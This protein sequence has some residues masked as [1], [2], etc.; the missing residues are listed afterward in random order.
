[1]TSSPPALLTLRGVS[2]GFERRQVLANVDLTIPS[3][4]VVGVVG[5]GGVGKSTL[6]R[7]LARV[8]EALP[9][10]WLD[11]EITWRDGSS[12]LDMPVERAHAAVP[13]LAQKAGLYTA[14]V[15][16]NAIDGM[17]GDT[18]LSRADKRDLAR[19]ALAPLDL[20]SAFADVLDEPVLS[21]SIGRQR[22]LS[23]ARLLAGGAQ[24]ILADEPLRDITDEEADDIASLLRRWSRD[25]AV[26]VITHQQQR[27]RA[28]CDEICLLAGGR[29]V[30]VTP[31]PTFFDAPRT[32]LGADYVRSGNCWPDTPA[33]D[34]HAVDA[35]ELPPAFLR[36]FHWVID[37]RLGGTQ[38]PGLLGTEV[39]DL[40]AL[41][42]YGCD[43][44]ITL[45]EEPFPPDLVEDHG[46]EPVHFPI[47]DM[48][49]PSAVDTRHLCEQVSSWVDAG[50]ATVMHCRAGLGRTGTMLA[51]V[52]VYRG[53]SAVSAVHEVRSINPYYIQSEAQLRFLTEFHDY[54]R[55]GGTAAS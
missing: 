31:A 50:K 17:R 22:L 13:L 15:L 47:V 49:V 21:L 14:S 16:D 2:L 39:D 29:V 10:F 38:W 5:P 20:W 28:M 7:T 52:L 43:Y 55:D 34:A 33:D 11:G 53:S 41:R 8:N 51:C 9:S 35:V 44:L 1:M 25:H 54:L 48:D 24:C 12:F 3:T 42:H 30:E 6:L 4:G 23:L 27:A 26:V 19:Q 37:G 32:D 46:M 18:A 40:R 45:T 36:S